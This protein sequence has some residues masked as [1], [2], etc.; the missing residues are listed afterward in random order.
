NTVINAAFFN[1]RHKSELFG[2]EADV[3][4][5]ARQDRAHTRA[6][7]IASLTHQTGNRAG[8]RM[9]GVHTIKAGVEAS[10]VA[11]REFFT[12]FI[13][14][15]DVAEEREVS[16][17]VLKYDSDDPFLFRDRRVRGQFSFYTQDQFSPLR[18]LTAQVGLRY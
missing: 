14:D 6:G 15:R 18:N 11:P 5:F 13:T 17:A 4:I 8:A 7:L 10:R 12:F 2:S 16:D 3:P 9:G 1:R